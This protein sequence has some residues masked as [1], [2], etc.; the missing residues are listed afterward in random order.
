MRMMVMSE[1]GERRGAGSRS[2]TDT[3][4]TVRFA[5]AREPL[6]ASG[7]LG[8]GHPAILH[9]W[10]YEMYRDA[11]GAGGDLDSLPSGRGGSGERSGAPWYPLAEQTR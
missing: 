3:L 6:W 9:K 11:P 4:R 7:N 1:A 8:I 10:I 5:I 2:A